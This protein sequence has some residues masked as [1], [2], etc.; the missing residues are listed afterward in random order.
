MA[1]RSPS[2]WASDRRSVLMEFLY[3]TRS[4]LPA[5][6]GC[7]ADFPARSRIE[8]LSCLVATRTS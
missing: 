1:L 5:F 3:V 8:T 6:T 4:T 7:G 2:T